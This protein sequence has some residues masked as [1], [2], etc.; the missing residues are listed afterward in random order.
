MTVDQQAAIRTFEHLGF[1]AEGHIR[2]L[3]IDRGGRTHD[4]VIMTH[5]PASSA[6]PHDWAARMRR[7]GVRWRPLPGRR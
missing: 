4:L 2:E 5:D 1:E 7:V 3:A 6:V